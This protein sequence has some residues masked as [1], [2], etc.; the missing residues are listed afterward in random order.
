MA[1]T[2][3][4]IRRWGLDW[5]Q[6]QAELALLDAMLPG[7]DHEADH[8]AALEKLLHLQRIRDDFRQRTHQPPPPKWE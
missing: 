1:D 3:T 6:L 7:Q 2:R 4:M 5:Q 8:D